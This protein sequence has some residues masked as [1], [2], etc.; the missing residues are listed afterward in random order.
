VF[1]G[2]LDRNFGAWDRATGKPLWQT[3]LPANAE[4]TPV[5]YAVGDRQFVAVVTGEGSHLGTQH[6]K[7]VPELGDM[8]TEIELVV[9]ALPLR[10]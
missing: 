8:K 5:T 6:R 10:R 1:M 4:S 2:D 3:R 7:L 9:F